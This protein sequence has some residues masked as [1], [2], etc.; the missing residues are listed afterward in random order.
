MVNH[1]KLTCYTFQ[2]TQ[3]D[4]SKNKPGLV[5]NQSTSIVATFCFLKFLLITSK[6]I[7]TSLKK[8]THY[9]SLCPFELDQVYLQVFSCIHLH[10]Q[11]SIVYKCSQ[12]IFHFIEYC[13][14]VFLRH[15]CWVRFSC[16]S[17]KPNQVNHFKRRLVLGKP[18][19]ISRKWPQ[20]LH[21]FS[22]TFPSSAQDR[23]VI[24]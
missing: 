7:P 15:F 17:W 11:D 10:C 14:S 12:Q 8:K 18:P 13:L 9:V 6:P 3:Q 23:F 24:F 20:H 16:L 5:N 21:V 4:W 22:W 1:W 19:P 2:L